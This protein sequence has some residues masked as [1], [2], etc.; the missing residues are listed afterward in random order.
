MHR[1]G[2]VVAKIFL[3]VTH[4]TFVGGE[5]VLTKKFYTLHMHRGEG[6]LTKIFLHIACS[7]LLDVSVVGFF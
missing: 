2:G 1:G 3:H 7:G 5:G 4:Y 6:V